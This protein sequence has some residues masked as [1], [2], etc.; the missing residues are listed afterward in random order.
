MKKSIQLKAQ[1]RYTNGEL[2]EITQHVRWYS[3]NEDVA[4]VNNDGLL[5]FTGRTGKTF[6]GFS[7]PVF[8]QG[9]T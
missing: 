8:N 3:V 1:G 5:T 6:I 7:L 9:H 2:R 4:R